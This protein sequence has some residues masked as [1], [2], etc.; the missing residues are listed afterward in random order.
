MR[1]IILSLAA[2]G[3]C[4]GVAVWLAIEGPKLRKALRGYQPRHAR[5]SGARRLVGAVTR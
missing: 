1:M 2:A 4:A 5:P 3:L